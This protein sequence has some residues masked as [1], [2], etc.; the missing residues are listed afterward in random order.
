M[1][2]L[3]LLFKSHVKGYTRKDGHYVNPYTKDNSGRHGV[4]HRVPVKNSVLQWAGLGLNP[5]VA[6]YFKLHTK[7]SDQFPD[8]ASMRSHVQWVM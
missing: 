2:P 6:D 4:Q 3:I 7:H 1:A 5:V 8:E